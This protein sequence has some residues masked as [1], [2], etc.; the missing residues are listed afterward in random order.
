MPYYVRR[1]R[2]YLFSARGSIKK[3]EDRQ[4]GKRESWRDWRGNDRKMEMERVRERDT[5][6]YIFVSFRLLKLRVATVGHP[7]PSRPVLCHTIHLHILLLH[8]HKTSL[9]P[10]PSPVLHHPEHPSPDA[11]VLDLLPRLSHCLQTTCVSLIYSFLIL[12][13]SKT[14]IPN[15]VSLIYSFL[16]LSL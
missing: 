10:P 1:I 15:L 12:R 7:S 8:I 13:F 11:P 5:N 4:I 6:R 3:I 2:E 16:I 14:L 9:C